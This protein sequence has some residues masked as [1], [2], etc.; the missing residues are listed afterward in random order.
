MGC[1]RHASSVVKNDVVTVFCF[2]KA[3]F[4]PW[5]KQ[6]GWHRN[7]NFEQSLCFE[8]KA[9]FIG[10][11]ETNSVNPCR[12]ISLNSLCRSLPR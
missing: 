6:T 2:N 8:H 1:P 7:R 12:K 9:R 3:V 10:I 5:T 4:S 11:V